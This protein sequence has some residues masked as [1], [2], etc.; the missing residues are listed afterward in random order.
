VVAWV[1]GNLLVARQ[2]DSSGQLVGEAK[3][4]AVLAQTSQSFAVGGLAGGDWVILWADL[5]LPVITPRGQGYTIHVKRFGATGSL[6]QDTTLA[7]PQS[8]ISVNRHMQVKATA[9]GGY[10]VAWSAATGDFFTRPIYQRF[11]ADGTA[12]GGLVFVSILGINESQL[13]VLPLAD[14]SITAVWVRESGTDSGYS[15]HARHFSAAGAPLTGETQLTPSPSDTPLGL[16]ATLLANG[17]IGVAWTTNNTN[18]PGFVR[19]QVV[20]PNGNFVGA[21]GELLVGPNVDAVD[22][23]AAPQGFLVFY[24]VTTGFNRGTSARITQL[25]IDDSGTLTGSPTV[26]IDRTLFSISPTFGST[27]GWAGAGFS[28]AGAKDGHFVAVFESAVPE[29]A[30]V[31]ALGR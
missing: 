13:N 11:A 29:G 9:D 1:S 19:W 31:N 30:E 25:S 17:N 27:T 14:G 26:G 3:T 24:Q 8:F 12:I 21:M 7:V 4:I 22:S 5:T 23:A 10:V 28:I 15:I 18:G 20:D 6:V 16:T 2:L